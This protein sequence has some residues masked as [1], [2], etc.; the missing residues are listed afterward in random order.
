MGKY[1][2]ICLRFLRHLNAL[3]N[4]GDFTNYAR[5]TDFL[6]NVFHQDFPYF[7]GVLQLV[8]LNE[9]LYLKFNFTPL[10]IYVI[11]RKFYKVRVYLFHVIEVDLRQVFFDASECLVISR[12]PFYS[13]LCTRLGI[14]GLFLIFPTYYGT[15]IFIGGVIFSLLLDLTSS[16]LM[17]KIII[18]VY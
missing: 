14:F 5:V 15:I 12:M 10:S 1:H 2:C 13:L 7:E 6:D 9:I 4:T 11:K 3:Y 18:V 8:L 17:V 16:F